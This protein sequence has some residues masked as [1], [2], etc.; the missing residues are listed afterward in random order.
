MTVENSSS[1]VPS[2]RSS[3]GLD[4]RH[5]TRSGSSGCA[6]RWLRLLCSTAL[7]SCIPSGSGCC[8]SC[9][10][11]KCSSVA[12]PSCGSVRRRVCGRC[13]R[14]AAAARRSQADLPAM[15]PAG[16]HAA[17]VCMRLPGCG[18]AQTAGK[19]G[20][21]GVCEAQLRDLQTP[22]NRCTGLCKFQERPRQQMG[23][24]GT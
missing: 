7:F 5:S 9:C 2:G 23:E 4:S 22:L 20:R 11:S 14:R 3:E 19:T 8:H 16:R 17:A 15:P 12:A 24:R 1:P 6:G 18:G 10:A 13:G 21:S